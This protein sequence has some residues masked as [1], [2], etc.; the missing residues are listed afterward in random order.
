M[1]KELGAHRHLVSM[2]AWCIQGNKLALVMEYVHGGNLHQFLKNHCNKVC[3]YIIVY[4]ERQFY[5]VYD[6]IQFKHLCNII[7]VLTNTL[8]YFVIK[9]AFTCK[10]FRR[11]RKR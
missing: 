7:F 2:L 6:Y 8:I 11:K 5:N 9:V 3:L 1:M 10:M 4:T